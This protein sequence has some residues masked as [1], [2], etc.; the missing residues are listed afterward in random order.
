[1]RLSATVVLVKNPLQVLLMKRHAQS[2]FMAGLHVF[3]GGQCEPDETP[4]QAAVRELHEEVGVCVASPEHLLLWSRWLTP[5][6]EKRRFDT[7]FF[8]AHIEQDP[9]LVLHPQETAEATW[10]TP[11]EALEA[12][13]QGNIVL[14]PPTVR[15]LEEMLHHPTWESLC[16][17]ALQKDV[18]AWMPKI[19]AINSMPTVLM[20]WDPAYTHTEGEGLALPQGWQP[21]PPVD[22]RIVLEEGRWRSR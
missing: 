13:A 22:S 20:P 8:I 3:P 6:S 14:V 10:F 12:Y 4:A 2:S 18:C 17:E 16:T 7:S 9:T 5:S 11:Q 19:T 15:T 21:R 1:M